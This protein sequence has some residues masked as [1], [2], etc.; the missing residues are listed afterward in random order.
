MPCTGA[1]SRILCPS[2]RS[3]PQRQPAIAWPGRRLASPRS[4][5]HSYLPIFLCSP[6][7]LHAFHTSPA[8]PSTPHRAERQSG[9]RRELAVPH[10]VISHPASQRE[11]EETRRGIRT[12]EEGRLLDGRRLAIGIAPHCAGRKTL[13]VKRR[14]C[15]SA[16][17]RREDNLDG[18]HR[19]GENWISPIAQR[20]NNLP[21]LSSSTTPTIPCIPRRLAFLRDRRCW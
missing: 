17:L 11:A 15:R 8:S 5:L 7:A 16:P 14:M 21:L 12:T 13:D 6:E 2:P 10:P 4:R 1:P 18:A 20:G 3:R 9:P 19:P